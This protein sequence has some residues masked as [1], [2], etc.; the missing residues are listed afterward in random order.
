[1]FELKADEGAVQVGFADNLIIEGF[2]EIT[3]KRRGSG[4]PPQKRRY[5]VGIFP[6]IPIEIVQK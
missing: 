6:A 4:P 3:P 5:S 2:M 1:M